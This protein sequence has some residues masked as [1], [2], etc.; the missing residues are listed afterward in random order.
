MV[1]RAEQLDALID[2]QLCCPEEAVVSC[3]R[4]VRG[5]ASSSHNCPVCS[6]A[7]K[8]AADDAVKGPIPPGRYRLYYFNDTTE[9]V[10]S[11]GPSSEGEPDAL[12]SGEDLV[13]RYHE[14]VRE[15][16]AGE[17]FV[18]LKRSH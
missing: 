1:V 13:A 18:F 8:A 7:E 12:S 2:K 5:K 11:T 17:R 9:I 6:R 3:D 16:A 10:C 14:Y 15:K 4:A